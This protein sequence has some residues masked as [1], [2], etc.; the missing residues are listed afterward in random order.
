MVRLMSRENGFALIISM[1][2]LLVLTI[3]VVNAARNTSLS[4]KMAGNYMDRTRAQQAA[5]QVL[6]QG[7]AALTHENCSASTGCTLTNLAVVPTTPGPAAVAVMPSAWSAAGALDM[8][9]YNGSSTEQPTSAQL[10]VALLA[11]SF[12]PVGKV[13]CKAYSLMGRGVGLDSR[14]VV[15]L[16]T[17]AY[18]C[19]I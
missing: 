5:E 2:L 3:L 8:V 12:L 1:L 9:R 11:D 17:V 10:S 6:R 16:Q 13:G 4:E 7:V 15:V 14:S 18:V 19:D